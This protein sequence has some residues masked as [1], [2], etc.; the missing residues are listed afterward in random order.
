MG[1]VDAGELTVPSSDAA[2]RL[3]SAPSPRIGLATLGSRTR[4]SPLRPATVAA[5]KVWSLSVG[6]VLLPSAAAHPLRSSTIVE[7]DEYARHVEGGEEDTRHA[8]RHGDEALRDHRPVVQN[9]Q[10]EADDE[11]RGHVVEVV[12]VVVGLAKARVAELR[13]LR[14]V[15]AAVDE[16]SEELHA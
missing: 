1:G 8:G 4:Y 3:G 13:R 2:H 12:G 10:L 9:Q 11:A 7:A 15:R 16:A 6:G 14:P 5:L